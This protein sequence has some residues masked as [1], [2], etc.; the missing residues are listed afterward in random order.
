[1]G[2]TG[3]KYHTLTE[4]AVEVGVLK[5][6]I[7]H[8]C[9]VMHMSIPFARYTD[10]HIS[11]FKMMKML[12]HDFGWDLPRCVTFVRRKGVVIPSTEKIVVG[13][14]SWEGGPFRIT[15]EPLDR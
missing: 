13:E 14:K 7:R 11:R 5:T 6:T 4:V 1:M 2:G 8:W 9:N 12:R 15:I 10:K 3:M